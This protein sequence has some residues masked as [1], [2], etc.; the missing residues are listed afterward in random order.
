MTDIAAPVGPYSLPAPRHPPA[1]FEPRLRAGAV[2]DHHRVYEA[3]VDAVNGW[4]DRHPDWT[5]LTIE[6][7]LRRLA[8]PATAPLDPVDRAAIADVAG[9]HANHQFLWK[10]LRPTP[11]PGP[12]GA[13]A[14][15]MVRDFGSVEACRAALEGA[16]AAH[17]GPGW[18]FLACRPRLDYRLEV[19]VL[20]GNG[21]VLTL[22]DPAPGLA[23]C[24]LWEHAYADTYGERRDAWVQVWWD[25]VDWAYVGE[26]LAG[27][28]AGR[29]QL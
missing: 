7:L 13:L 23:I 8:D 16:A 28:R 14:E 6:A 29:R 10:V 19:L 12:A 15:G 21:S 24:D 18:L 11:Q 9:A 5:G 25:L 22:T 26:R 2:A 4:L 27:I 17:V 20:P 1:A 3:A